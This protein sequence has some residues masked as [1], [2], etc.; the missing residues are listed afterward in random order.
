MKSSIS[1]LALLATLITVSVL[2]KFF[3]SRPNCLIRFVPEH[4]T[5]ALCLQCQLIVSSSSFILSECSLGHRGGAPTAP[6]WA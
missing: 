4:S 1:S 6:A 5:D 2:H 3:S